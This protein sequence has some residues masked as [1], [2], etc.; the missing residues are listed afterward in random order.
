MGSK[1]I[2]WGKRSGA[3]EQISENFQPHDRDT[4]GPA[5]LRQEL[6]MR[7]SPPLG[8]ISPDSSM[9]SLSTDL[10]TWSDSPVRELSSILRSFP[11]MKRPSAG[12]RSPGGGKGNR[13]SRIS[14]GWRVLEHSLK[15]VIARSSSP[16]GTC[17]LEVPGC[18]TKM[19]PITGNR[20]LKHGAKVD[21]TRPRGQRLGQEQ[22]HAL[23]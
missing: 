4:D 21:G 6:A 11:W 17:Y 18:G 13:L 20:Q 12:R 3:K 9:G 1:Y 10:R 5:A 8:H 14:G 7:V 16:F 2:C 19:E 23:A 22:V 15:G